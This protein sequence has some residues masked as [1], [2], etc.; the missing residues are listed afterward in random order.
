MALR[1]ISGFRGWDLG[2]KPD[3]CFCFFWLTRKNS[4]YCRGLNDY[5]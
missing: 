2:F 4:D 3:F 5:P 1:D